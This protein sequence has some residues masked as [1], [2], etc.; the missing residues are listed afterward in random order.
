MTQ[1]RDRFFLATKTGDRAG[2][3]ARASLERSLQRLGV[4]QVD[5]I[6]LHNL[7]EEDEWATAHAKGGAVEFRQP[8]GQVA[9]LDVAVIGRHGPAGDQAERDDLLVEEAARGGVDR[10]F[11]VEQAQVVLAALADDDAAAAFGRIWDQ[12][13]QLVVDLAL[14]VAGEGADP[15]GAFV[16]LRPDAGGREVA[17][18]LAGAGAGFHQDHVGV[19]ADFAW[20]EGSGGG[21]GVV[22]LAGALFGVR[23]EH[24]GETKAGLG[25]GDGVGGWRGQGG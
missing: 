7:V 21:A 3:E 5:L 14:Q 16:F 11:H 18:R 1:H 20:R 8:A 10:V 4:D 9:A 6:Q 13:F 22:A 2:P 19:A 24:G 15:D 17:Q 12:A 23:T 25:L